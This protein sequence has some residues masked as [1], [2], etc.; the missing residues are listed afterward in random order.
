MNL[1]LPE[2][3]HTALSSDRLS[4]IANL[5]LQEVYSTET[6][7]QSDVDDEY[8]R[9]CTLFGRQKNR[10]RFVALS[11]KYEWL[12]LVNGGNDLVFTISGI[13]CRFSTDDPFNPTKSAVIGISRYQASFFEEAESGLPC[14]FCFIVDKGNGETAEPRVVFIGEDPSGNAQCMWN[15]ESVRSVYMPEAQTPPARDVRKAKISPKRDS[16]DDKDLN[17][18]Q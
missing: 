10:I 18:G 5:L 15:S 6:E 16:V 3:F 17:T 14:K 4:V 1:P 13:P 11:K 9:G 8:T 12:E 2:Q 7:L